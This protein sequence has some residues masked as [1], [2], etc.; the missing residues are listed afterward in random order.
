MMAV[1]ALFVAW[2][3]A[4]QE[5]QPD[6]VVDLAPKNGS[7]V[8]GKA[9]VYEVGAESAGTKAEEKADH[10][11]VLKL[12]GLE[13]DGSYRVHLHGGTCAE[14][15]QVLF[16][17]EAVATGDRDRGTSRTEVS[18]EELIRLIEDQEQEQE[19]GDRPS[20]R[21]HPALFLQVDRP[22]GTPAACGDVPEE[23]VK[24][25]TTEAGETGA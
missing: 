5:K 11:V 16:P 3:V 12:R 14:G 13:S 8:Q 10:R 7:S 23:M 15:G 25:G 20:E 19:A 9:L 4:A 24:K 18:R 17:L 1:A 22:G 2:P 6:H 21:E